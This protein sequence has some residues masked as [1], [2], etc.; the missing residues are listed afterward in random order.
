M[1]KVK[2]KTFLFHK[3]NTLRREVLLLQTWGQF[4]H[5][6]CHQRRAAYAPINYNR[7]C[8]EKSATG[9]DEIVPKYAGTQC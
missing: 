9:L 5:I 2:L 8:S 4:H 7:F 3:K 1:K 6:F